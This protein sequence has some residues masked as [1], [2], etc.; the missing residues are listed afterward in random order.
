MKLV[1]HGLGELTVESPRFIA[2]PSV[3]AVFSWWLLI[4]TRAGEALL[5]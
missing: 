4:S 5:R 2:V 3:L 1:M